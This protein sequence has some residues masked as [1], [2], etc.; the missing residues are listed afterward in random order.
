MDSAAG[1]EEILQGPSHPAETKWDCGWPE[2][3]GGLENEIGLGLEEPEQFPRTATL[4]SEKKNG[5]VGEEAKLMITVQELSPEKKHL[6]LN[7]EVWGYVNRDDILKAV[8]KGQ[9]ED[10]IL[11][12]LVKGLNQWDALIHFQECRLSELASGQGAQG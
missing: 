2:G 5:L 7:Q 12:K 11:R 9:A 8:A 10:Q 3:A 4:H 1:D 6:H